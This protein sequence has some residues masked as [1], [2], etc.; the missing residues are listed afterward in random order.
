MQ[1]KFLLPNKFKFWG[2]LIALPALALMILN[3]HFDFTFPFLG[4][5]KKGLSYISFDNGFLFN[6]QYNNFTDEVGSVLLLV[7][8]LMIAFSKEKD[9]DER[10]SKLRLESLLWAVFVNTIFI[11]V[12]VTFFYSTL[13]LSIMAY[14]I[15]TTLIL[16]IIRF[17]LVLY[18]DRKNTNKGN[19]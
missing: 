8:L 9:E 15:C 5:A 12:S 6:I 19:I 14:N 11:I 10:I 4:Y 1:T 17:N 2:W 18:F 7:G 13:F 3:V 16:F